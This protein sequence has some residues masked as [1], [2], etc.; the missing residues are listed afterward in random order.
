MTI[1]SIPFAA[2]AGLSLSACN[3]LTI[4][5]GGGV[6]KS[7]PAAP[8]EAADQTVLDEQ[9]LLGLELAYKAARLAAETATDAGL[10]RGGIA[11]RIASFDNTA[12]RALGVARRAYAAGNA[13]SYA[14]ALTE[15][16]AALDQLVNLLKR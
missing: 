1:R 15:G 7:I 9:G 8:I 13:A 10:V 16:R 2:L 6:L 11:V 4:A 12:Y 5:P 14:Q 3:P